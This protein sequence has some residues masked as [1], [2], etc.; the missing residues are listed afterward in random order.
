MS[1][2]FQSRLDDYMSEL[3]RVYRRAMDTPLDGL[4]ASDAMLIK[5]FQNSAKTS[6]DKLKELQPQMLRCYENAEAEAR[7]TMEQDLHRLHSELRN[8]WAE[9]ELALQKR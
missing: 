9:L 4:N 5:S 1:T 7:E 3:E 8:A 2:S 6:K